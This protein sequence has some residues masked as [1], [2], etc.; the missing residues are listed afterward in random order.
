VAFAGLAK[1]DGH[2]NRALTPQEVGQIAGRAGRFQRDGTFGV[3]GECEDMDPDLVLAVE[4]HRFQPLTG[5]EWRNPKIDFSSLANLMRGLSA[6]PNRDGLRLAA[7]AL[8]EVTLKK[9]AEDPDVVARARDRSALIKLWDVCQTPD[10]RKVATDDHVRLV[11][12]FFFQL[13]G[14]RHR[15]A[16]DWIA[17]QYAHLDRTEGEIDTLAARLASVRTLAY[18][19][20]RPDWLAD[21]AEWQGKTRG[22]EDRLSDTLHEKLMA[23]FVDRRTSA[24]MRGLRVRDDLL[25][26]V[27]ADGAV[28]VE[29]HYVGK[30]AGVSFESVQGA[31]VLEEKALRAAARQALGPEIARRLGK[32]AAEPD[33]AFALTPDGTVLW[34]GEAVGALA[35]GQPAQPRVRLY[36]DLGHEAARERAA[37]R[38]EASMLSS[39]SLPA[40]RAISG[41]RSCLCSISTPTT[42]ASSWN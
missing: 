2:R 15:V 11:K 42:K 26:G 40:C 31:T 5:A 13:T 16:E 10:F 18:V 32:L 14:G 20:N 33:E 39:H 3:T 22:L 9:L 8:D 34:R 1:F 25:A 29:G 7:E 28:T 17:K 35:G 24:L 23:R 30:L 36:G 38:L 12:D 19:A 41:W 6:A 37:H 4:E 21:P 27:A